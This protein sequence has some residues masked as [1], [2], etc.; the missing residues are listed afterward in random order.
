[1]SH[2]G[3]KKVEDELIWSKNPTLGIYTPIRLQNYVSHVGIKKVED[4]LIWSK[5]PT[6]GVYTPKRIQNDVVFWWPKRIQ[7]YVVFWWLEDIEWW[8]KS[9]WKIRSSCKERICMCLAVM[10]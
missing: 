5:N 6:L 8:W 9:L 3:I 10:I 1:M 2:V 7:N 4:V